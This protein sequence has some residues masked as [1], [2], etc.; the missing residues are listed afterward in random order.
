MA[1]RSHAPLIRLARFK[2][3]E[4][5]KQMAEQERAI[6]EEEGWDIDGDGEGDG[7]APEAAAAK[8]GMKNRGK[9]VLKGTLPPAVPSRPPRSRSEPKRRPPR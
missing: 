2:V 5:Q 6:A 9:S 1:T 4:L 7:E 8:P 3:E